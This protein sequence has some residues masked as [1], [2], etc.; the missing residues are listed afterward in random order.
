MITKSR[1]DAQASSTITSGRVYK[2]NI[3]RDSETG[4]KVA[5]FTEIRP[6]GTTRQY[7]IAE[8]QVADAIGNAIADAIRLIALLGGLALLAVGV[9]FSMYLASR[10]NNEHQSK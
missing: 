1:T 5:Y 4:N 10:N 3:R 9:G 8:G 6:D 7:V 2:I